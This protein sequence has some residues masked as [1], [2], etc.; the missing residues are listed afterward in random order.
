MTRKLGRGSQVELFQDLLMS[1][2][3]VS[4]RRVGVDDDEKAVQQVLGRVMDPGAPK[5][6]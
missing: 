1:V 3:D 4:E 6:C 2:V 5:S